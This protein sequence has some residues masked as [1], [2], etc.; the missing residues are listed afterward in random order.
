MSVSGLDVTIAARYDWSVVRQST[1]FPLRHG[2]LRNLTL[3][4]CL[5]ITRDFYRLHC[6]FARLYDA[7]ASPALRPRLAGSLQLSLENE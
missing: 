6:T 4:T 2:N 7:A 1:S 3:Q 5:S